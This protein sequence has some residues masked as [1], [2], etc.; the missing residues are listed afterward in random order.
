[1]LTEYLV[2]GLSR[3]R[4]RLLAARVVAA[5]QLVAGA[6]FVDTFR[7]LDR[8]YGF[9]RRTAY[10]ITMRTYRG[11]GLTK[12]MVYL[13]GLMEMLDY[14]RSGGALEPLFVG[15]IATDH[16]PLIQELRLR[17]ILTTP[18]LRPCYLDDPQALGR[19]ERLREGRSVLDLVAGN[20]K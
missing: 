4:M 9:P 20:S 2:G 11:G 3:P 7:L 19:L 10:T 14:L 15:K 5:V 13:R 1:M 8:H 6:T 17:Q 12:D 16:I 18:P